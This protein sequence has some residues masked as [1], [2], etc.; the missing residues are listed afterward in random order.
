MKNEQLQH[1]LQ[2]QQNIDPQSVAVLKR[3]NEPVKKTA[4]PITFSTWIE[5]PRMWQLK[6]KLIEV[7]PSWGV[8]LKFTDHD[9]RFFRETIYFDVIGL[10][11]NVNAFWK[12]ISKAMSEFNDA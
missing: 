6:Q 12:A 8:E 1:L 11:E 2:Q 3:F 10:R 9:R 4:K 5:A 7:A